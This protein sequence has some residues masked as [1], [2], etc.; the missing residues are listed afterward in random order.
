MGVGNATIHY[1]LEAGLPGH[2]EELEA[3]GVPKLPF[4]GPLTTVYVLSKNNSAM[5]LDSGLEYQ[6]KK[7]LSLRPAWAT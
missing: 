3:D 4:H 5:C 2:A 1:K 6:H 7:V